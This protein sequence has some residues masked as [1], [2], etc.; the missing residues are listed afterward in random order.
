MTTTLASGP[1]NF[2]LFDEYDSLIKVVMVG[3]ASCGKS[4]LLN[5]FT[6]DEFREQTIATIGVDFLIRTLKVND[7]TVKLQMWDTAGQERFRTITT[8]YYRGADAILLVFDVTLQSSFDNLPTWLSEIR[9]YCG[10]EADIILIGN[11]VD[12]TNTRVISKK[13]AQRFANLLNVKYIETS[14]KEDINVE[15]IFTVCA[16]EYLRRSP[17][18]LQSKHKDGMGRIELNST[19]DVSRSSACPTCVLL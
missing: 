8:A 14:A 9:E 15:N 18:L 17:S 11:K 4:S 19:T 3:D 10:A 7:K 5:R 12:K 1:L 16:M 2:Q 6:D 13:E